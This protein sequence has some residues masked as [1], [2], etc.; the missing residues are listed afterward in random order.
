MPINSLVEPCPLNPY[1]I[2]TPAY[3]RFSAGVRVLHL[4]A[5]LLVKRGQ[6]AFLLSP[7][8][9]P[10]WCAPQLTEE[11]VN[12]HNEAG[13]TPIVIYPE[14]V[15][16][17]PLGAGC[18]VRYL[19]NYPGYFGGPEKFP[20]GDLLVWYSKNMRDRT[21]DN[22]PVLGPPFIDT[23]VFFPSE[24]GA[25]RNGACF[26]AGR[27]KAL[28]KGTLL[29]ITD[30]AVEIHSGASSS[31]QTQ[32][33]I[34]ELFRTCEVFYTYESTGLA[35]EAMLC[36]CPV[37]YIPNDHLRREEF[38]IPDD[39]GDTGI[40]W[41]L[42]PADIEHAKRTVQE[43]SAKFERWI[44][45][46]MAQLTKFIATT[47]SLSNESSRAAPLQFE[48]PNSRLR[49]ENDAL[50]TENDAFRSENDALRSENSELH[51]I[52]KSAES[53]QRRSWFQ[54]A[55]HRWR[56]TCRK[57]ERFGILR[58]LQRSFRKRMRRT[59]DGH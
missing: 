54:R 45:N 18:V 58:K 41:G 29:P 51:L 42:N 28:H 22:N 31:A 20:D 36:G 32:E 5:H 10:K 50:R 44:A 26:Y 27:Y 23:S 46:S 33:E 11:V 17:N 47:Q 1:Y 13:R 37:I 48:G 21:G 30:G 40:C 16:G 49:T 12:A 55:F 2:V 9:N 34:A 53:W 6:Q 43:A 7:A 25:R 59:K 14:V 15:H 4:L 8:L 57:D 56:A 39:W 24:I 52:V 19:L 38:C 3:T 35:F